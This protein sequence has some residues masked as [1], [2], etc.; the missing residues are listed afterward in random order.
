MP[1][2]KFRKVAMKFTKVKMLL[3]AYE[4][5]ST[6]NHFHWV[7]NDVSALKNSKHLYVSSFRKYLFKNAFL[8]LNIFA[9]KIAIF[10]KVSESNE[11]NFVGFVSSKQS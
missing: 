6:R 1:K 4:G 8:I 2:L 3:F 9:L 11:I 10:Q 7:R 5:I